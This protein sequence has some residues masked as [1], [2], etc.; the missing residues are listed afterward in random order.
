MH[1]R[2]AASTTLWLGLSVRTLWVGASRSSISNYLG[3]IKP[4]ISGSLTHQISRQSTLTPSS[5]YQSMGLRSVWFTEAAIM[6][7]LPLQWLI[8]SAKSLK[9]ACILASFYCSD[10]YRFFGKLIA[11]SEPLLSAKM[12]AYKLVGEMHACGVNC[13]PMFSL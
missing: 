6:A 3:L 8:G 1:V 7:L 4:K 10:T 9:N 2:R 13:A 12:P 11:N 5:L